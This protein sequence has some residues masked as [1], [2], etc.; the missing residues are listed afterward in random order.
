MRHPDPEELAGLALDPAGVEPGL[1]E[2]VESC[3]DC[4]ALLD[5]LTEVRGLAGD[6]PELLPAPLGVRDRVL[7]ATTDEPSAGAETSN[8][9]PPMSAAMMFGCSRSW[10]AFSEATTPPTGPDSSVIT[11]RAMTSSASIRPPSHWAKRRRSP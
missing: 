5:A 6:G 2:H 10:P 3:P 7:A 9:V 1:G 4:R 8:V 11:G